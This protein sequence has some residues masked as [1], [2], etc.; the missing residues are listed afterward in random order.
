MLWD[1][2][3]EVHWNGGWFGRLW[4]FAHTPR[5]KE[6]LGIALAFFLLLFFVILFSL[7]LFGR[8]GIL[9]MFEQRFDRFM[10]LYSRIRGPYGAF[11]K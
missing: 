8:F 9:L 4:D 7:L 6:G 11:E 10:D 1:E 5:Q 2:D 3:K